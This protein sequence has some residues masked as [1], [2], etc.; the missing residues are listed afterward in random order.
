MQNS[1]LQKLF[2]EASAGPSG[3]LPQLVKAAGVDESQGQRVELALKLFAELAPTFEQEAF[4]R[5]D[6]RLRD[7]DGTPFAH[8]Q[9]G[10]LEAMYVSAAYSKLALAVAVLA[11]HSQH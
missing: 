6:A 3:W 1:L 9:R 5:A 11:S 7:Y 4:A 2:V 8:D 10:T